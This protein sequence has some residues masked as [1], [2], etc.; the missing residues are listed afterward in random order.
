MYFLRVHAKST[1]VTSDSLRPYGLQFSRFLCPWDSPGK[2]TG[3]CCHALLQRI[4]LTQG[5]NQHLLRLLHWQAA[6]WSEM[7]VAQ[8]CPTL[9][10]PMDYTVYGQNTGVGSHFL[11]QGILPTQGSNPYLLH[12]R[13]IFTSWAT[14]RETHLGSSWLSPHLLPNCHNYVSSSRTSSLV[15]T[16]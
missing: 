9:C 14:R 4:S 6:T 7:K 1:S 12:C 2:N 8:S 16:I 10:D 15:L 13:Q 5:F 3:V 11:L